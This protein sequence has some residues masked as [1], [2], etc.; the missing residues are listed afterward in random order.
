MFS[1]RIVYA[2]TNRN[3]PY[4]NAGKP[5][6]R[7]DSGY[8]TGSQL[9]VNLTVD[10]R[11]DY[12]LLYRLTSLALRSGGNL[13]HCNGQIAIFGFPNGGIVGFLEEVGCRIP[14]GRSLVSPR[15]NGT[16]V[17]NVKFREG[18]GLGN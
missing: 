16:S 3:A 7:P 8:L 2:N 4:S 1:N 18:S 15:E 9:L 12:R 13:E 5:D 11:F 17:V 10:R 14:I 6:S